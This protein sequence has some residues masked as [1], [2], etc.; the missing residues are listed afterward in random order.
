MDFHMAMPAK[1]AETMYDAILSVLKG[2]MPGKVQSGVFGAMMEVS[3]V[4]DGR[5]LFVCH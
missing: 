5:K 3:I 2:I 1:Q 4:N